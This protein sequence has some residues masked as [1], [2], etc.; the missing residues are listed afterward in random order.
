[1]HAFDVLSEFDVNNEASTG[2][3]LV[4][5]VFRCHSV[6][7]LCNGLNITIT[8]Y[9]K[10]NIT[11]AVNIKLEQELSVELILPTPLRR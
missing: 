4:I 10:K 7:D 3:V 8:T 9:Q 11:I 5:Y 2:P 6:C 1:M